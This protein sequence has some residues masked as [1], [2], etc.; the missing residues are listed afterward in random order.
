LPSDCSLQQINIFSWTIF[1]SLTD[2]VSESKQ[3]YSGQTV[4]N[5]IALVLGISD[6]N[7]WMIKLSKLPLPLNA[8]GNSTC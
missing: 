2:L 4:L 5:G 3:Y 1:Y 7:N 6:Y 8:F